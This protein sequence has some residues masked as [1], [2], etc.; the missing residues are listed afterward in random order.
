MVLVSNAYRPFLI[1][2]V[3]YLA[4]FIPCKISLFTRTILSCKYF[5]FFFDFFLCSNILP[6]SKSN[7]AL[8]FLSIPIRT[9]GFLPFTQKIFLQPIPEISWLFPTFGCGYPYEFFFLEKFCFHPL[10][11]LLRHA[12][13]KYFF[14]FCLNQKNLFTKPSWNNF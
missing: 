3:F 14:V 8:N 6:C 11:A 13:Q 1:K 2:K 4:F 12:V 5:S 7:G 10:T 9:Y